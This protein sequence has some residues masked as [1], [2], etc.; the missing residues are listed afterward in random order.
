M[1]FNPN[2]WPQEIV[3]NDLDK[4]VEVWYDK[5]S[6]EGWSRR[7]RARRG[8]TRRHA[9]WRSVGFFRTNERTDDHMQLTDKQRVFVEQFVTHHN[10][11][12]AARLAGYSE[13]SAR[14]TASRLKADPEIAAE[15]AKRRAELAEKVGVT[16]QWMLERLKQNVERA[17]QI[18]AVTN[19]RGKTAGEFRY[20]GAVANRA[21]E[22]IAKHYGVFTA[23]DQQ[24][25]LICPHDTPKEP[26]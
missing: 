7:R 11:A 26:E 13:H 16:A 21:L 25:V 18:R 10:G 3:D 5:S 8:R 2:D 9:C 22:L 24:N 1:R 14:K 6:P 19:G 23:L 4:A 15:I 20:D 12:Q 17:M